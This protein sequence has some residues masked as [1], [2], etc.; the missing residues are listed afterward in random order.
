MPRRLAR[1]LMLSITAIVVIVAAVSGVVNVKTEEA[2][3]LNTMILGADQL[4][5]GITSAIWHAMR[6][7]HREAAYEVMQ[8]I[9]RKQGIDRI[10][11]FNRSGQVMFS[12][13]PQDRLSGANP[14][15]APCAMCHA[16]GAPRFQLDLPSR[17]RTFRAADGR[18][19]LT[20]MTAIYNEPSC[21]QAECHAHPASIKVLGVLDLSLTL[22]SV[23]QEMNHTKVRV[24][25]VTAVEV[26]LIGLFIIFF[27]RRFLSHAHREADRGHQG[28]EPDGA[29][30][31]HRQH[32]QQR[33]AERAGAFVRHYARAPAHG[34][35]RD[36]RVH[37][38]TGDQG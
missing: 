1:K 30:Q 2:Q 19:L 4:S 28:G 27:T 14:S 17:V 15:D 18:R 3:L 32:R 36:Q 20:M 26:T 31:A 5:K 13:N 23:D 34:H 37:A 11:M 35:V 33:G 24:L 29:G 10:R 6:D 21:S 16:P 12:T 25:L 9:A 22:D 38:E 8:T 7:D